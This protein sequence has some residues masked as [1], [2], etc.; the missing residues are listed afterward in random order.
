MSSLS[1]RIRGLDCAEEVAT[2]KREVGPAV[3][4]AAR[5]SFD[6]LNARMNVDTTDATA[7][8]QDILR[9]IARTGMHA[10]PWEQ[11]I[12][13]AVEETWWERQGRATLT[14]F[15]AASILVGFVV[16]AAVVGLR[17]ALG[18]SEAEPPMLALV[19]YALAIVTGGYF[20][21]PRAF[22]AVRRMHPDMNLLMLV[23][24]TGAVA[25]GEWFEAASVTC[26]FS[27][28]LLLE[29]WSVERARR[30]IAGLVALAPENARCL[31]P[32]KGEFIDTPVREV[33][34]ETIVQVRPGE[35]VPLDGIIARGNTD[36]N[37][38][39]ITG[40]S[41]PVARTEG[42]EVFAGSINLSGLIEIR[43][44]QVA[45]E[46]MIA[47]IARMVEDAQA[48]RAPS[49]QWVEAFAR[50]YT[51]AMMGLALLV[52]LVPPILFAQAWGPWTYQAL[53]LLVIACPCA[54]VISTP[55]SIVAALSAAARHGV[56]VKG[57]VFLEVPARL[58]AIAFDKTGTLTR[59]EPSVVQVVPLNHHDE[60]DLLRIAAAL[61]AHS[62]HPLAQAILRRAAAEGIAVQPAATFSL[63][64][65]KG[66]TG[67]V[68]GETYWIGSERLLA[69]KGH[70]DAASA[71]RLAAFEAAG[72]S[73]VVLGTTAHLC[74]LIALA[75]APRAEA[76]AVL[77]ELHTLGI[78]TTMLT[79]DNTGT[80]EA[81]AAAT[82]V[83]SVQAQL[84][85]EDKVR[86]VSA[87]LAKHGV[88]AMVGDGVNDAP[89][90]ATASLGIA[91]GA[92]GTEAALE[93]AD[94]ALMT[95]DLRKLPWLIR[96]SRA[97]LTII[98][99]NI[100]FALGT[101]VLFIGLSA[102]GWTTL[103]LAIAADMGASLLVIANG[104]RLAR[105]D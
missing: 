50:Y 24:V 99:Q 59:G 37:Q 72:Q 87:L 104:L 101:K 27:V 74:G 28:A 44:T 73:V 77:A 15:S 94:I 67:I 43:T 39:P 46:T 5:L 75:D 66:A 1:Y 49:E 86:A 53:V 97:T 18:G 14:G 31:H 92:M 63:V 3:G 91:M 95:D 89:A 17:G 80:A 7:S 81:V 23:A 62:S 79:G 34:L 83:G 20:V 56:L 11:H 38:A 60:R 103:W 45:G 68:D 55:V 64:E 105:R 2:L 100:Y 22:Y 6:L 26:L 76:A 25:I 19:F 16:H 84:L 13:R 35:R 32:K 78:T 47:R 40:E 88:V 61:E 52:A 102:L 58:R 57:G 96:H 48:R 8:N 41:M 30:A 42:D 9:A 4:D 93:T 69:D 51:P 98:R 12:A 85:P 36:V 10:I 71:A 33:S 70:I 54:L 82:G 29:S 65:G 90:L 21:A